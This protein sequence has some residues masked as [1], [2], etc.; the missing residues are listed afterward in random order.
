VS[1]TSLKAL[2]RFVVGAVRAPS[3][4]GEDAELAADAEALVLP[5]PRGTRPADRLE[6][7]RD[8][9][10]LRHLHNLSEDY[11]TLAWAV[12]GAEAFEA[13]ARRYLRAH[14]PRT[15]DLQKLGADLPAFV[16][17]DV[18]WAA[19]AV[20]CDAAR[21]DWA[22]ME[23]F[24]APD[25]APLDVRVLAS[26]P[27]DA[28]PRARLVLHPSLRLL[29][30]NHSVHEV[31]DAV[32]RGDVPARPDARPTMVV[33]WRDAVCR[34]H[35]VDVDRLAFELLAALAGGSALGEAC[36]MAAALGAGQD[37]GVLAERLGAWFQTWTASGWIA[38][39]RIEP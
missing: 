27:E 38:A 13:L 12:G 15:W 11:P 28:W 37:V 22:F 30:L 14:P 4:I 2:Q 17:N 18:R 23:A 33:V 1:V 32:R 7:Y 8:Q 35:A 24:D 19:D 31:R 29:R 20:A 36:E 21:I 39:V 9:F 16:A 34:L 10:W 5:G 25:A 3:P 26:T 6:V